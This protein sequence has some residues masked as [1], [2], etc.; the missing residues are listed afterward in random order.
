VWIAV[1]VAPGRNAVNVGQPLSA[2]A[3]PL[4][5]AKARYPVTWPSPAP[6]RTTE[7]FSWEVWHRT[8][9][10]WVSLK[11]GGYSA[12]R[13]R[14]LAKRL[15]NNLPLLVLGT[16]LVVFLAEGLWLDSVIVGVFLVVLFVWS[17]SLDRRYSLDSIK[18]RIES[19]EI[20]EDGEE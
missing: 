13:V 6:V 18:K 15:R 12:V 10:H 7:M 11:I 14:A 17:R 16:L 8:R 9:G 1:V 5:F 4:R 20:P 3:V 19:G 2:H